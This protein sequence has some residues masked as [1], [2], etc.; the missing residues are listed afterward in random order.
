M[1][2]QEFQIGL[3]IFLNSRI[4]EQFKTK[5]EFA[6]AC[7]IDEKTV[8]RILKAEQNISVGILIKISSSLHISLGELIKE[9][10]LAKS[11]C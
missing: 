10:E 1:T 3:A 2:L 4:E 6:Y 11:N 9:I 5:V 7:E 8:R